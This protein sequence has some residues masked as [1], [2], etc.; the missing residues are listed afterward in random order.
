MKQLIQQ[1]DNLSLK[2][3]LILTILVLSLFLISIIGY[4]MHSI[5]ISSIEYQI[6]ENHIESISTIDSTFDLIVNYLTDEAS[7]FTIAIAPLLEKKDY[8][9][10]TNY[11]AY[12]QE[13]NST[14]SENRKIITNQII[15]IT[16]NEGNIVFA[17]PLNVN[18]DISPSNAFDVGFELASNGISDARLVIYD[19]A[20][21][22]ENICTNFIGTYNFSSFMGLT[23]NK[24]IINNKGKQLGVL[25]LITIMNNNEQLFDRINAA[26]G[27]KFATH[28]PSGELM[29]SI[30]IN[31]PKIPD[32]ILQN[33]PNPSEKNNIIYTF[34]RVYLNKQS[35]PNEYI[36]YRYL[37]IYSQNDDGKIVAIHGIA[38]D[39]TSF[40]NLSDRIALHAFLIILIN[41]G[42]FF[43]FSI[44]FIHKTTTPILELTDAARKISNGD[45][46]NTIH[47]KNNNEIGMLAK[48]FNNIQ[49]NDRQKQNFISNMV[50]SIPHPIS[51]IYIDK[52][53]NR[54]RYA[55]RSM[56]SLCGFKNSDAII[57]KKNREIVRNC[58][59]FEYV[60]SALDG[61]EIMHKNISVK[62]KFMHKYYDISC[63]TIKDENEK[64]VGA[65]GV[66]IDMTEFKK[67]E[68]K[69]SEIQNEYNSLIESIQDS[70]Y[71]IDMN[72]KYKY[73]NTE[74]IIRF[75]GLTRKEIIGMKYGNMD[76]EIDNKNIGKQ[77]KKVLCTGIAI[78]CKYFDQR[79]R[80]YFYITLKPI[81]N[82]KNVVYSVIVIL[83][84]V[85]KFKH[86]ERSISIKKKEIESI[87]QVVSHDLKTPI[88]SIISFTNMLKQ[89]MLNGVKEHQMEYLSIIEKN[90]KQV[91]VLLSNTNDLLRIERVAKFNTIFFNKLVESA[92]Q[93]LTDI[94][95]VN[96]VK[97]NVAQNL[98]KVYV[99]NKLMIDML[100]QL[101]D[102][103]I[104][105][106]CE[107]KNP[108]IEIGYLIDINGDCVF[109]VKDN[110]IGIDKTQHKKIFGLF[111]K[112][113]NNEIGSGMGLAIVKKTV[114]VH[115]G[116]VWV[117]SELG[118]GCKICFTLP[119]YN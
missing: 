56:A 2:K 111:Y 45:L 117:E 115:G 110:G 97:I 71:V 90:S 40:D 102:N 7:L 53:S 80:S 112:P 4:S 17:H 77:I 107:V 98:P 106:T 73:I 12:I 10:I 68:K 39:L 15:V 41:T 100:V 52:K 57:G 63:S 83:K 87:A 104:K 85:T 92:L 105:Y 22:N 64:I 14:T 13:L 32:T 84:D 79:T 60:D 31:P 94:I 89:D 75:N 25:T 28:A 109:F 43:I 114:E 70:I 67:N 61:K 49:L 36:P 3:R 8:Q 78:D 1:L 103:S 11:I 66:F 35:N 69:A 95:N 27:I 51:I 65:I 81:L 38:Y 33:I 119:A 76:N 19:C 21:I 26:S 116:K 5:A 62:T 59:N 24:P 55:N 20:F 16:N 72:Y 86:M 29:E 96:K 37:F 30:F 34:D 44:I 93:Q 47:S 23:I 48:M 101:I 118:N 50:N 113:E 9:A 88:I 91:N 99:D 74:C 42:L 6:E 46:N 58:V 18:S 54:I 108:E 82:F